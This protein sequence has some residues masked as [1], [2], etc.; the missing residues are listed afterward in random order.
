MILPGRRDASLTHDAGLGCWVRVFALVGL[1]GLEPPTS[2]LS[3]IIGHGRYVLRPRS[4]GRSVCPR[5]AVTIPG[6]P[7]DRARVGHDAA[8]A[9][10][11]ARGPFQT[12]AVVRQ[13]IRR[14]V[15][16][17]P[18]LRQVV[19]GVRLHRHFRHQRNGLAVIPGRLFIRT[20]AS[21]LIP[22]HGSLWVRRLLRAS[23]GVG[24]VK[25]ECRCQP[26]RQR[27]QRPGL[28]V[29]S[30][31]PFLALDPIGE[32]REELSERRIRVS[33]VPLDCAQGPPMAQSQI[34]RD[35]HE[36]KQAR[37]NRSTSRRDRRP[38]RGRPV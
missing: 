16:I 26:S 29:L 2:S 12:G 24:G 1:G 17:A 19:T 33:Q 9:C 27:A 22:L 18:L 31:A 13:Q 14:T 11:S 38:A 7:S 37:Q 35:G 32:C 4:V 36:L 28:D 10:G 8:S 3:G 5:V 15:C 6:R 23:P 25:F 20:Q 30:R 34:H 21:G